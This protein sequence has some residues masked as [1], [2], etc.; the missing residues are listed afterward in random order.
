[1]MS[2]EREKANLRLRF[3]LAALRTGRCRL[4]AEAF[5]GER[6]WR[7]LPTYT[8]RCPS[9]TLPRRFRLTDSPSSSASDEAAKL[10]P[11]R[12]GCLRVPPRRHYRSTLK[13]R[14]SPLA[15]RDCVDFRT[16]ARHLAPFVNSPAKPSHPPR[17]KMPFWPAREMP[18][19]RIH[20]HPLRACTT[21]RRVP[22]SPS[23]S[24]SHLLS[25]AAS[26]LRLCL[27]RRWSVSPLLLVS[28]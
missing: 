23:L 25:A 1:M 7:N 26:L 2:A 16:A 17:G 15:S 4:A 11:Q 12:P 28:I 21:N 8:R 6:Y 27:F 18:F 13:A 9:T 5:E 10:S 24:S 20:H 19:R 22:N 3:P 14:V